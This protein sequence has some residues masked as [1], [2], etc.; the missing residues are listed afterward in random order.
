MNINK[1]LLSALVSVSLLSVSCAK[2]EE[3]VHA[4]EY[5]LTFIASET[6]MRFLI[7]MIQAVS[8]IGNIPMPRILCR[9]MRP[10][11]TPK[12]PGPFL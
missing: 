9:I 3:P 8:H 5:E 11:I 12:L 2:N 10:T 6:I 1:F 7:M 4:V